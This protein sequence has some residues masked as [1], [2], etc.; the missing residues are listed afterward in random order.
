ME[1][2]LDTPYLR[3]M[4]LAF[5]DFKPALCIGEA[6]VAISRFE[7]GVSWLF[8]ILDP[9]EEVIHRFVNTG[10]HI[11]QDLTVDIFK[12]WSILFN[13]RELLILS[14]VRNRHAIHAIGFASLFQSSIVE[15]LTTS[16]RPFQLPNLFLRWV[17]AEFERFVDS[18]GA[19]LLSGLFQLCPFLSFQQTLIFPFLS[20]IIIHQKKRYVKGE[21][22]HAVNSY[23]HLS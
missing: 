9:P 7:P 23:K 2:D 8:P 6:V 16:E 11:L 4:E 15:F 17:D 20:A 1:L 5:D 14:V 21:E 18:I 10:E 3:E 13:F 19:L 12:L 22:S